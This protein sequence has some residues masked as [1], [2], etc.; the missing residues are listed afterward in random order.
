MPAR[1]MTNPEKQSFKADF[2]VMNVDEQPR[3]TGEATWS[4][5]CIAWTIGVTDRW[6]NPYQTLDDWDAFYA[7]VGLMRDYDDGTVAIWRTAGG[8]FT[9]GCVATAQYG[10]HWE[11][12][13]GAD[14]RILHHLGD[15]VSP[16]LYG[17]VFVYYKPDPSAPAPSVLSALTPPTLN[18]QQQALA[19]QRLTSGISPALRETFDDLFATWKATWFQGAQAFSSR[20]ETRGG[21][22]AYSK[23]LDLGPQTLPLVV[24]KLADPANFMAIQL[25][26]DLQPDKDLRVRHAPGDPA[27]LTGVQGRARDTV[28]RYLASRA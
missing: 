2:P 25:Y 12:K 1:N 5:N 27:A 19:F 21:G 23:L 13:C 9:H 16:A 26:D 28:A 20:I 11:S 15:L 6:I 22:Y 4:Y 18:A 8:E 7:T 17:E 3:V 14:L 24:E 10:F